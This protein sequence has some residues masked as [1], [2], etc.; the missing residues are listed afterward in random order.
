[1]AAVDGRFIKLKSALSDTPEIQEL[2]RAIRVLRADSER[3][4]S[5]DVEV[6]GAI[7]KLSSHIHVLRD[8]LASLTD[9]F[10]REAACQGSRIRELE[11][12]IRAMGERQTCTSQSVENQLLHA[13]EQMEEALLK[14][15]RETQAHVHRVGSAHKDALQRFQEDIYTE[16]GSLSNAT[17]A[18]MAEVAADT[19]KLLGTVRTDAEN[20]IGELTSQHDAL[21]D[22]QRQGNAMLVKQLGSVVR[23]IAQLTDSY[24]ALRSNTHEQGSQAKQLQKAQQQQQDTLSE[25]VQQL[26]H[27]VRRV[28][29][30]GHASSRTFE[31]EFRSTLSELQQQLSVQQ[32][33]AET[34]HQHLQDRLQQQEDSARSAQEAAADE[35]AQLRK[36]L[37]E[38][39][40][41]ARQ[42]AEDMQ[43]TLK[44]DLEEAVSKASGNLEKVRSDMLRKL[45]TLEEDLAEAKK[46][47][48]SDL[49]II[50][51]A[52]VVAHTN[53]EKSDKV[54][55]NTIGTLKE[56]ESRCNATA[57]QGDMMADR[58]EEVQHR[59]EIIQ[60]A[61]IPA[62]HGTAAASDEEGVLG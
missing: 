61:M 44:E 10:T 23:D 43:K 6:Y 3:K 33:Q 55:Q 58:V 30:E 40:G 29:K 16:I 34:R 46:S 17:T 19:Q 47:R 45:R 54:L 5:Q 60:Q 26:Q 35:Y 9:A 51:R 8:S 48:E 42:G 56:L 28:V 7:D 41:G 32:Q 2:K 12:K 15:S 36:M 4:L 1:M 22:G 49:E 21:K 38:C 25:T 62:A 14:S 39:S 24:E 11:D 18:K 37:D 20:Q 13:R 53:H 57:T 52:L 31:G 50:E 59:V 27:D